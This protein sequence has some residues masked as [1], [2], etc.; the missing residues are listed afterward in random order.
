MRADGYDDHRRRMVAPGAAAIVTGGSSKMGREIAGRMAREGFA[1]VVVYLADQ[2]RVEAAVDEIFAAAGRAVAVRADLS[3]DLDVE[4]LFIESIAAFGAI[5]VL[6]HTTVGS[7]S[8]LYR[9]AARY[10]R[11]G[12]AIVSVF[13]AER[14]TPEIARQLSERDIRVDVLQAGVELSADGLAELIAL[15][16]EWRRSSAR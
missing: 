10:L 13:S 8:G 1:I 6:L 16:D 2:R 4:R 12:G 5:D 15:V 9:Y 11:D 3:D 14:V 7:A